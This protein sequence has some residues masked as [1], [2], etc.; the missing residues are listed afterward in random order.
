MR[1]ARIKRADPRVELLTEI[2]DRAF[3]QVSWHGP[4]LCG[5]L[6]GV[7]A[8]SASRCLPGRKSIW[9]QALHAAY[10]KQRV[11][12][13]LTGS[14][15]FPRVGSNWPKLPKTITNR[16]WKDDIELLHSIHGKL[17]IAIVNLDTK[18]FHDSRLRAMLYGVAMHDTY[19]AG[20]IR[21][22]RKLM[23]SSS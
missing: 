4:N 17:R 22:L 1:S 7:D 3:D 18:K 11:I 13:K 21:L 8:K 10:W 2:V 5:A 23:R 6:R 14:E 16:A 15:P 19:H 12:N 20:Q 9:Q